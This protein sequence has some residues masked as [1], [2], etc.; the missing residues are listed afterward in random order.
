MKYNFTKMDNA[1]TNP[2][3]HPIFIPKP[4][5]NIGGISLQPE[6]YTVEDSHRSINFNLS[7]EAKKVRNQNL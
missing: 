3:N 7:T 6:L 5:Q 2:Q 4:P 1:A